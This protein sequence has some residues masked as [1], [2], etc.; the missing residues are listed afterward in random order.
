[1]TDWE[2]FT[3]SLIHDFAPPICQDTL[4]DL[5]PPRHT[6]IVNNYIDNFIAYVLHA[7]IVSKLH[8]TNL[9]I[10]DLQDPL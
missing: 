8:W 10:T 3:R 2:L 1:M 5:A 6:G 7:G 9:F 4:G